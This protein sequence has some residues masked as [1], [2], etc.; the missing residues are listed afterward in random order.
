MSIINENLP[1]LNNFNQEEF[2]KLKKE[3]AT[4]NDASG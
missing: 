3:F 1:K 4:I 2:D